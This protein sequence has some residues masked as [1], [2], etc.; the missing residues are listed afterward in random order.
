L[1]E[2]VVRERDVHPCHAH[3]IH[4]IALG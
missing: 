1:A 4:T 3:N 2:Q